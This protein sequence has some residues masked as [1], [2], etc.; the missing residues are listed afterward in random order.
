MEEPIEHIIEPAASGRSKC[1][2]CGKTIA[3]GELRLGERLPNPFADGLMTIWFHLQCA[4]YK[5]PDVFLAAAASHEGDIPEV[6][7]MSEEAALGTEHRRLPRVN[8]AQRDPSGRAACRNCRER[9]EKDSWRIVL[10]FYEEGRFNPAGYIHVAC[11]VD[12]FETGD[13]RRRVEHF[14]ADLSDEDLREIE[15]ALGA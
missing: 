10:D 4:A 14:S 8:G 7:R 3:R 15:H 13:I 12:Y 6:R 5:R 1:R 9:I 11:A 2:G